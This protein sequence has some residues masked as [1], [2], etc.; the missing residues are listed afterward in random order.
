MY[1]KQLL[2]INKDIDRTGRAI[3][4]LGCSFVQGQGAVHDSLYEQ[5]NWK[6]IK[7][8][9]PL[10]L[11]LSDKEKNELINQYPDLL[12]EKP[13]G[14]L[15]FTFM[16]Y[17]NAF[18]NVLAKKYFEGS[19]AVINL[20]IL[21]CGNR[22]TIKE[23]YFHPEIHWDKIKEIIVIYCPSGMERFDFVH[24]NWDDHVHFKCMWPHPN[25]IEEGP[26]KILWTGYRD[27]LYSD[28]FQVVEQLTHVQELLQWCHNK[29]AKLIITPAFDARYNKKYFIDT[30]NKCIVRKMN[31][32]ITQVTNIDNGDELLKY[33]DL[34][35][36]KNMFYPSN[37]KTF[38]D[39]MLKQEFPDEYQN[40][41]YFSFLGKGTPNNY[42]TSC[43]HPSAKGHDLFAKY[44]FHHI[45]GDGW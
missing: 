13:D 28:K 39:L 35:P 10:E 23:L 26:R 19:Y 14:K 40:K 43:V 5:Y 27:H 4:A 7:L 1:N 18:P 3:I 6:Y 37:T 21:G 33:V 12:Y 34:W 2:Q 30:L 45:T 41:H 32:E 16:E 17:E 24:D 8:G 44:L 42:L 25:D 31:G 15:N 38:A 22:A 9:T 20:G 29:N 11:V 36:W